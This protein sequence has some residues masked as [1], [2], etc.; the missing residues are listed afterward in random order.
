MFIMY[1]NLS[2]IIL[3]L[4]DISWIYISFDEINLFFFK[5]KEINGKK[6]WIC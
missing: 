5:G 6:I 2:G 4:Y 3:C 1:V